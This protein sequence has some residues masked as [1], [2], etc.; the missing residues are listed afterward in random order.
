M[1]CHRCLD[2]RLTPC[3]RWSCEPLTWRTRRSTTSICRKEKIKNTSRFSCCWPYHSMLK[4]SNPK[5]SSSWVITSIV[6]GALYEAHH[7]NEGHLVVGVAFPRRRVLCH[8]N[9]R[10]SGLSS[11]L[12]LHWE[13]I[14][15]GSGWLRT[16]DQLSS[17]VLGIAQLLSGP[18]PE[19]HSSW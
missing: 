19:Y 10:K 1:W 9:G 17:V 3:C 11:R 15:I 12:L 8:D 16:Q 13:E 14:R 5:W 6:A 2:W 7:C 18:A 4:S